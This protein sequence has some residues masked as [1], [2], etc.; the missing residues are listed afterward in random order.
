MWQCEIKAIQLDSINYSGSGLRA[1]LIATA[2]LLGGA[3]APALIEGP[4]TSLSNL[5]GV[6]AIQ[7]YTDYQRDFLKQ[8]GKRWHF[9]K[10]DRIGNINEQDS[11]AI[12][13]LQSMYPTFPEQIMG[14]K[15][16]SPVVIRMHD[17]IGLRDLRMGRTPDESPHN[18]MDKEWNTLVE[19][20]TLNYQSATLFHE[21]IGSPY[22]DRMIGWVFKPS[23][24]SRIFPGD[25]GTPVNGRAHI[26]SRRR[27]T[28]DE[29]LK[30]TNAD[31]SSPSLNEV[32]DRYRYEDF[33]GIVIR[34]PLYLD[35]AT[36]MVIAFEKQTNK[37]LKV[38]AMKPDNSLYAIKIDRSQEPHA[39]E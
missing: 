23:T 36:K 39:L 29:F 10:E 31:K 4:K 14:E 18:Q 9:D 20:G 26:D 17:P 6:Q 11:D 35:A 7:K 13:E 34:S 37:S 19:K 38:L 8:T 5:H 25:A 21:G 27:Y 15:Y 32:Y 1:A 22:H 2:G 24:T 28:V 12:H 3:S 16:T 33:I 30:K